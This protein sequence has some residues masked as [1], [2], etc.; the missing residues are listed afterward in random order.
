MYVSAKQNRCTKTVDDSG[1]Y[2]GMATGVAVTPITIE[3]HFNMLKRC[4]APRYI[5]V[6]QPQTFLRRKRLVSNKHSSAMIQ[7][8][9]RSK[10]QFIRHISLQQPANVSEATCHQR[11]KFFHVQN[12]I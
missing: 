4:R 11:A 5:L 3:S 8:N 2:S 9:S 10:K 1:G 6:T 7:M 12:R